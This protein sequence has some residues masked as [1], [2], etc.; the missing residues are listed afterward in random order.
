[1]VLLL[2]WAL[3][4]TFLLDSIDARCYCDHAKNL[5]LCGTN[6]SFV[7]SGHCGNGQ[8]CVGPDQPEDAVCWSFMSKMCGKLNG[9]YH[10]MLDVIFC[11]SQK[12]SFLGIPLNL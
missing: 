5:I 1:M 3:S 12:Y 4:Y 11:H 10:S 2:L 6:N 9:R 7:P 8:V